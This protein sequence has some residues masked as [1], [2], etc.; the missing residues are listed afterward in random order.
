MYFAMFYD[1]FFAEGTTFV[2]HSDH[3][4]KIPI[5]FR[6]CPFFYSAVHRVLPRF[7]FHHLLACWPAAFVRAA[8]S[9]FLVSDAESHRY[10]CFSLV[11]CPFKGVDGPVS[12]QAPAI[13]EKGPGRQESTAFR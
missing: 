3:R 6:F 8:L 2:S 5:G 4:C 1:I 11:P 12:C 7:P 9:P 13:L 10:T